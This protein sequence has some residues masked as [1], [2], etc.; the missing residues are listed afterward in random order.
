MNKSPNFGG[1]WVRKIDSSNLSDLFRATASQNA[2]RNAVE[3]TGITLTYKD[4]DARSDALAY[5]LV[6]S[7]VKRGDLVGISSHRSPELIIAV[8]AVLKAGAGYVPFDTALPDERLEFMAQDTGIKILLGACAQIAHMD[9]EIISHD[10]FPKKIPGRGKA[11]TLDLTSE[12]IAYVMYTSGTTGTPKGVM[13]PHRAVARL[14]VDIDWVDLGPETV[15]LHSSAFA[16][17]TSIIDIFGA[18]LNGGC[19]VVPADGPMSFS[20]LADTMEQSRVTT[21][22]LTSGLFNGM[23]DERIEA[24]ANIEQLI[25]G[26]DI[27]SP[28]H[29]ARVKD[30]FPHIRVING[31]GPTENGV[32]TTSHEIGADDL[33]GGTIPIGK[34]IPGTQVFL[35]DDDMKPVEPG[36]IG[37]MYSAG[38]GVALGYWKRPELTQT[39][40]IPAPWDESLTL[41]ASGDMASD[42]GDGVLRFSG[43]ADGQLKIRGNRVELGEIE[44]ALEAYEG[45]RQAAVTVKQGADQTDKT[46]I[47]WYVQSEA[48]DH[49]DLRAYLRSKL[50]GYAV[51]AHL[52]VLDAL[53]VN[54]NGKVDRKALNAREL[55]KPSKN[56]K[57]TEK[58]Q[59]SHEAD[60]KTHTADDLSA[61]MQAHFADVLDDDDIDTRLNFF[62]LGAS[63]LHVA[64][65]HTRLE[66]DLD[67]RFPITDFF[68]HSTIEALSD[69]LSATLDVAPAGRAA[70]AGD[71]PKDLGE[72]LIA[73]VGM[74]GRFPGAQNITQFWDNIVSGRET[75]SQFT[76]EELDVDPN[77]HDPDAPY[78]GARGIVEGADMFDA[79]HFGFP[80]REAER[81]DPQHRVL[82]EVAQSALE[83]AGHDP[84]R[85]DGRVGIFCGASQSSY[86]L[87]NLVS[88]PGAARELAIG[89]PSRDLA[90]VFGND[91]D[92][93]ATRLA[94]KL[95]LKGP[96][97]VVQC[98][99]STSL[100]AV[101]QGC[102]ALRNNH[103]D[104][105]LAGGVSITFPTKRP[106]LYTP[107]GMAAQDGHCR[108]FDADAT[109][110]VFGDGAGLVVLRRLE[111]ALADGD[112]IVAVIRGYAVNNDGS[113]KAGYAAPSIK[114]QSN[115]VKA[116]HK[117]AGISPRE[118]SYIEAHG[119]GTPLGD[120]IEFAAL[121]DAFGA[122]TDETGFCA[123]GSVKTNIGHLDIASGVTGLI[124]AALT[125]KHGEIPALVHY[126]KPNPRINFDTS[127]FY[128]VT[129]NIDWPHDPE[130]PRLAG[131]TSLGV[132]GTN[133]HMVLEEAPQ[134][135]AVDLPDVSGAQVYPITGSSPEAVQAGM[136]D[137]GAW[138]AAHPDASPAALIEQLR[139]GRRVYARR[140][141][142]VAR[143]MADLAEKAANFE[144]AVAS[145]G[146]WDKTAFLFPGQGAQHVGMGRE[147]FEAE[148]VFREAL[149][150]CATLLEPELGLNILD[151]IHAPEDQ[152]EQMTERLK[153]TSLAQPAIFAMGYALAKQWAHWG[154]RPDAMLGHS[155]GEFA[156]ATI[157]GVMDLGDALKLIALRGRLM[158]D[159]PG[160]VMMSVRAAQDEIMP[161]LGED[162]DTGT[163][164]DLAAVNG[165]KACVVAGPHEA[166]DALEA[167]LEAA[168]I[169][170]S[171][172][173]TSHAFH[174]HMMDAAVAPFRAAVAEIKLRAPDI[175]I[176][177][178]VTGEWMRDDQAKDPDYWANHMRAPVR[179]FDA[180]SNFWGQGKHIFVETGPGRTLATLAGQN[181]ERRKAAPALASL[182]HAQ[183]EG[184]NS[185]HAMLETFGM[186]WASGYPVDWSYLTPGSN[187]W[188]R[189]RRAAPLP[190]YPFQRKRHWVEPTDVTSQSVA[191]VSAPDDQEPAPQISAREAVREMLSEM[192][193]LE[194][195]EIDGEATFFE[196]GFDSLLLTQAIKEISDR[197]ELKVSLRNLMET[198]ASL[199]T[200]TAH[201]ESNGNVKGTSVQDDAS[202]GETVTTAPIA[203]PV[204]RTS[205][206]SNV[207]GIDTQ[208][209]ANQTLTPAG[210]AHVDG[211][212]ARFNAK[213]AKSKELTIKYRPYHADPRTASGFN[214][215]WKDLVY[216]IVTIKSKG[217]RLIDVDG[218]EYVDILNGFGPG[219]LGHSPDLVLDAVHE[220]LDA[221]FEI[222]PQSLA[223]MEASALFSEV[224]GNDRASFVCTGSEAVA[225]AMRLARVC[226]SRDK[227]VM[228]ARDYHGNFDEVQVRAVNSKDGPKTRPSAAGIPNESVKNAIV[229]PYGT[230]EA[231]A[232]IRA[233]AHEL[234]AV[235]VEPVQSRR[236]EFRP[237]E[238]IREVREIT[239]AAGALFIFDEV[240]TGFR[241]G[242]RGAQGYYGVDADLVTY[243]KIPG[244]GLPIGIVSGKAQYMDTFDGGQWDY[245]DNSVPEAPV[246][247]FAGTFVRHPLAMASL[248]AL[249]QFLKSQPAFFWKTINAK[250]DKLAGTVDSWFEDN[251]IPFQM[252]NCGSLMYLRTG[253]DQ[254]FGGLLGANMRARGVFFLEGFPSYT[255]AAHDDEDLDFVIEAI[256]DSALEMR[257]AGLITGREAIAYDSPQVFDPPARLTLPGGGEKIA[258][259]MNTPAKALE[260]PTTQAQREIWT[261]AIVTPE[262]SAAYNESVTLE[263]DGTIDASALI[264]ATKA[265]FARHDALRASFSADGTTM[266]VLADAEFDIPLV[267][268]S[269]AGAQQNVQLETILADEAAHQFDFAAPPLVRAQLVRLDAHHHHLIINAHHIVCDGWS[270]DVIMRDISALYKA[271]LADAPDPLGAPMSIIDFARAEAEWERTPEAQAD[272]DYW[273]AQFDGPLPNLDLP[274]DRPRGAVRTVKGARHDVALPPTLSA[275]LR[276]LAKGR[277]T[278]FVNLLLAAFKLYIARISNTNDIVI[279]LPAAG[280]ASRGMDSVVGHCVNLLPIRTHIDWDAGFESYLRDVQNA[281]LDG[282]EHQN[283]TYGALMRALK[284]PRNTSRLALV[285]VVFNIDNG[286]D[287]SQMTFGDGPVAP[288]TKF[289]TNP[290]AFEHFELYLN[291]TD[292]TDNVLTEWSYNTDLFDAETIARHTE[293]FIDLLERIC[294]DPTHPVGTL[295]LLSARESA[296]LSADL[297]AS[298]AQDADMRSL[299]EIFSAHAAQTPDASALEGQG[300]ALN[301]RDLEA[302]VDTLATRLQEA[303][304]GLGDHAGLATARGPASIIASLACAKAGIAYVPLPEYFAPE[305]LSQIIADT[306]LKLV[307]GD[308]PALA[309]TGLEIISNTDILAPKAMAAFT[310]PAGI[311]GATPAYVM[312][313]SGSTGT[314]KG[315]VVPQRAIV[316]LVQGQDFMSLG[317]DE[318][319]LQYAPLAFDAATL[320]I[321][322]ALLNGGTLVVPADGLMALEDLGRTIASEKITS[323]WLTA[324]LFHA[325]ADTRPADFAPLRQLLTGGD[326]VSP[327]KVGQVMDACPDLMIINGYG[328]TENTTFTCCHTITR[329]DIAS[330]RPLP[331]GTAINGTSAFVLDERLNPVPDGDSGEL[332][333][334]GPGLALGYLGRPD[335]TDAVF[336]SAPWAPEMRL[337]RTGDLVR[338]EQSGLVHYLGRIDG[339]VKIRGFRVETGAIESVLE[340]MDG[341]GQASVIATVPEGQNDK[342]LAAYFVPDGTAPS[343][344]DMRAFVAARLPDFSR[345]AYYMALETLPLN[346]NGKVDR[347]ALP[348]VIAAATDLSTGA[349]PVTPTQIK[350]ADIWCE[351]LGVQ[352]VERTANFFELGGHSL[353][354]VR[355]MDRIKDTFGVNLPMVTLFDAPSLEDLALR[356]TP[357][358]AAA[359]PLAKT[360]DTAPA[361]PP[362][363][364]APVTQG[365]SEILGA[366]LFE[367]EQS[368]AYNLPFSL[369]V[370]GPLDADAMDA[371]LCDVITRHDVLR[372]RFDDNLRVMNFGLVAPDAITRVDLRDLDDAAKAEALGDLRHRASEI[373]FDLQQAP[374]FKADIVTL[375]AAR[376]EVIFTTHHVICDG[377]SVGVILEDLSLA[378]QARSAG[379]APDWPQPA[380]SIA[381][382]AQAEADW[383]TSADAARQRSY[384]RE[385]FAADVPVVDVPTDHPRSTANSSAGAQLRTQLS[386]SL[387]QALRDLARSSGATLENVLFAAFNAYIAR[388]A[389][390]RDLAIGMPSPG[391]VAHGLEQGVGHSVNFLP[392]RNKVTAQDSFASLLQNVRRNQLETLD[393]RHLTLGTI[394]RELALKRDGARIPLVPISMTFENVIDPDAVDLGAAQAALV[395]HER[396]Y[397]HFEMF[398][399][400]SSGGDAVQMEWS[401]NRGLFEPATIARHAARFE[402]LLERCAADPARKLSDMDLLPDAD[403]TTLLDTWQGDIADYA[404]DTSI[405][406]LFAHRAAQSAQSIALIEGTTQLSYQELDQLANALAGLLQARGVGQGDIVGLCLDRGIGLVAGILA[407]LRLGAAYVPLDP[408]S[409]P[410]RLAYI[411]S[412]SRAKVVI[413]D[414]ARAAHFGFEK[415]VLIETLMDSDLSAA[416]VIETVDVDPQSAAYIPYTSGSTGRPK[417]VIGTHRATINRFEWMWRCFPFADGEVM[418]QKT[419]ISFVD[420]VW[421][422]LGPLL[423]GVPQVIIDNDALKE[424]RMLLEAL[425]THNVTRLLVV[426]SLLRAI[427]KSDLD[428]PAHAPALK[429]LFTSGERLPTDLARRF[430][431]AAPQIK[432][433]NLYGSS[434]VT[435]DVTCEI[436]DPNDTSRDVPIGRPI[437]NTRL[438][439]LDQSRHLVQIGEVGEIYIGGDALS[440]GYLHRAELTAERFMPDPFSDVPGARMFATGDRGMYLP[441]GRIVFKGRVDDQIKLR[442]YRIEPGEVE[443]ALKAQPEVT[444]AAVLMHDAD[445]V[446]G[447]GVL[448]GYVTTDTGAPFD[449]A[450]LRSAL[451]QTLPDYMIP[452]QIT[453]LEALPLN[454]NGKLDRKALK[455]LRPVAQQ[456]AHNAQLSPQMEQMRGIWSRVLGRDELSVDDNFFE[457]GGHSLMAV[458][459]IS[460]IRRSFGTELPISSLFQHGTA[461]KFTELVSAQGDR[462]KTATPTNQVPISNP[463]GSQTDIDEPWD[464]T[465]VIHEGPSGSTA[466]PIF[467]VGGVGG[468][469][470]NL[471][472]LGTLLGAERKVIGLQTRGVM[473]HRMQPSIEEMASDHL[474]YMRAY[475]SQGPFDLIGYSGGAWTAFEMARQLKAAGHAVPYLGILDVLAPGFGPGISITPK[476]RAAAEIRMLFEKGL[477]NFWSRLRPKLRDMLLRP[478]LTNKSKREPEYARLMRLSREWWNVAQKYQGGPYDGNAWLYINKPTTLRDKKMREI[479]VTFGWDAIINGNVDLTEMSFD[480]R[481]MLEGK[482]VEAVAADVLQGLKR[483]HTK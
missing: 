367:P 448:V 56:K 473:G 387:T 147:L 386:T 476:E 131:V 406:A 446:D 315:V 110:T 97:V 160:G 394:L 468:N 16:F 25:V 469:V 215:L 270:I 82:L 332:C 274:T 54:P 417:G 114:A 337:Y 46:L 211:L 138:A 445:D 232:Y 297:D 2:S 288:Q 10:D 331:I 63:S 142:V 322:G 194:P 298:T 200:L 352:S 313:T 76:R 98:A 119:T 188:P 376:H 307:L 197:F 124:K 422:I 416:P 454:Q 310:P 71:N 425:G 325:M 429:W 117:A 266:T 134:M 156:A 68:L 88:A 207:P 278:T 397:E 13:V 74:A 150:L 256:K 399:Y 148:K 204:T 453:R 455:A 411:V 419:A 392:I 388:I 130:T 400:V 341:I 135:D 267:D 70:K 462:S 146:R 479:D 279:G 111:D 286:I 242:P 410:D 290:R 185:H 229:L 113:D 437:D 409:P 139:N 4:L 243:G 470:N 28:V 7:G 483:A 339:Q 358:H 89:Y 33:Q 303:G 12:D 136:A 152:R 283:L 464:T 42:P 169:T 375:G 245:G 314:P 240:V 227:I 389:N 61:M 216:Q 477:G 348:A 18:L 461:R 221:G 369:A 90:T 236:P 354:A 380:Q 264:T 39:T 439:L 254:P 361:R 362:R 407:S 208:A 206:T 19:V 275:K 334:A 9:V 401:Y 481:S 85:F 34:T 6:K 306:K 168:G 346:P 69:H 14:V 205:N 424:P 263:L 311:D 141:V 285:P 48:I 294:D 101:S 323:I 66:K 284:L 171:R 370:D 234:A 123:I 222:G 108:T 452:A 435:A 3:C 366:I 64:R 176:L 21:L 292:N 271:A 163:G 8:F 47:A 80:P 106:Y 23:A 349:A 383:E 430:M 344:A 466:A 398:V 257:A 15:T 360:P 224:T 201:V 83:D 170:T 302:H 144:G 198:Y 133:I 217:S 233:H 182:P 43:R 427:L 38:K 420:S 351:I 95:N 359:A 335:L 44:A 1:K 125:L 180:I 118:I 296:A 342:V 368:R 105:V 177:S 304:L 157:A 480:H 96:A 432:L 273:L 29:V 250:G 78:V 253:E 122:Q 440:G 379:Q 140:S 421:E 214:R 372:A 166:A 50:P 413:T 112:E 175:P 87:N 195:S 299:G 456:P 393:N 179:F 77:A 174:S 418:C 165:A 196:L 26:G 104:M 223:A 49:T 316:R 412:D 258:A 289:Y 213:T 458:D 326:V 272:R 126:Q 153:D 193:G 100:V 301:Y 235:M 181:P 364:S 482:A 102:D 328:P 355:L 324:G 318:R 137:L 143:D 178:T 158:S 347:K 67:L 472:Q 202:W 239:R 277:G 374:L 357:D 405:G 149:S 403:R 433:V 260:L 251:D 255:T 212:V 220:Q 75:I 295:S 395:W 244:G 199:D 172:L 340:S 40:F 84:D 103:A 62:D 186:L 60:R 94:Y 345:P 5:R 92:F 210:Q 115:V 463:G 438:Y 293:R 281:L 434:E 415:P 471:Y 308:S 218:N 231:L 30:K 474:H 86:L 450:V 436:V 384:W 478:A 20:L 280:Q 371:A 350:L 241:F 382:L 37:E 189:L 22:W 73:I 162:T 36:A 465:T 35:L 219:F 237:H 183:A 187:D 225:A 27:V 343:Q 336:V 265:A 390:V 329:A 129:E 338:R 79:P 121:Q 287:L 249:L 17:D 320:E 167:T 228:F 45:I 192:S 184:A 442:G 109:G 99:C 72:G 353:L 120:P 203:A 467:I 247:F 248:R 449:S 116:A 305:Q 396:A 451:A 41:Y 276:D 55:V 154:I 309:K 327:V 317:A 269:Q 262:V 191:D 459:L 475:Q 246:T 404:R 444:Q 93:L 230:A 173:H 319:I 226:T 11:P 145:A 252:P 385:T 441:D 65:V 330:G 59:Q 460:D 107:D 402:I 52:Q 151:I 58:S 312:F 190:S 24:F 333:V 159:L 51:P 426:P 363:D 238:F 423:A 377:W 268:L 53:P 282:F 291:V 155:I 414:A 300:V 381:D 164:M 457:M 132:G 91:K 127:A 161:Y 365:Q 443:A 261:A 259:L 447:Y 378:Y 391:Q 81:L 431:E 356:I 209:G 408:S 128:P 32:L 57:Q 373:I 321:W 428:L 31:F